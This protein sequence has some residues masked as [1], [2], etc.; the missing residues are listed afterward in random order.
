MNRESARS[1]AGLTQEMGRVCYGLRILRT[2]ANQPRRRPLLRIFSLSV[3]TERKL[4]HKNWSQVHLVVILT[5]SSG[6]IS[7]SKSMQEGKLSLNSIENFMFPLPIKLSYNAD[8]L[9]LMMA[10]IGPTNGNSTVI[11]SI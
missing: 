1:L 6:T 2:L 4:V 7:C 10:I 3:S 8:F 9:V 5:T 11:M